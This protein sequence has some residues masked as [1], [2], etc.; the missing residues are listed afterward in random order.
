[1]K[2]SL[3]AF[4]LAAVLIIST[5][6]VAAADLVD[7]L[8]VDI[9][10]YGGTIGQYGGSMTVSGGTAGPKTFNPH[11]AAETSSSDVLGHVLKAW[12]HLIGRRTAPAA[13]G[14]RAGISDDETKSSSTC[15]VVYNGMTEPSLQRM[16]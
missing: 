2:K 14:S 13:V 6:L 10:G 12:L 1:M 11:R 5:G 9:E 8:I 15:A 4:I 16:T 7:P 3:F